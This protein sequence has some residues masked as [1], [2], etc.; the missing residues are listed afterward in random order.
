MIVGFREF[1]G[2]F[3]W[4]ESKVGAVMVGPDGVRYECVKRRDYGVQWRIIGGQ[5][6]DSRVSITSMRELVGDGA[7]W[8]VAEVIPDTVY[9]V[10]DADDGS[11]GVGGGQ[12]AARARVLFS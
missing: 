8:L 11:L 3:R 2:Q 9:V 1:E 6:E 7:R 12:G 5:S 10:V 4:I